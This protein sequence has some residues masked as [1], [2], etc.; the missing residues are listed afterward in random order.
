MFDGSLVHPH[1]VNDAGLVQFVEVHVIHVSRDCAHN[2]HVGQGAHRHLA[3]LK[4]IGNVKR[5]EQG[6]LKVVE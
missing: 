5:H 4:D 2:G 6:A 3:G 1:T